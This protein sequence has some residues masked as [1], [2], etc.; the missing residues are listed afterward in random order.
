MNAKELYIIE[1]GKKLPDNV[2]AYHLWFVDYVNWLEA[3]VEGKANTAPQYEL[4]NENCPQ[5]SFTPV[6]KYKN[7]KQC[8]MCG[9][10]GDL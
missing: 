8:E 7:H 2:V 3:K 6:R 1:T 4:V 5:C 10:S 9:H